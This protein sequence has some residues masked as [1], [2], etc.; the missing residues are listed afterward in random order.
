[1]STTQSK[2]LIRIVL[3]LTVLL[4]IGLSLFS[5]VGFSDGY[6]ASWRSQGLSGA[7]DVA[8][9]APFRGWILAKTYYLLSTTGQAAPP[10]PEAGQHELL[11]D[12]FVLI[13]IRSSGP[14]GNS[15][16]CRMFPDDTQRLDVFC[17]GTLKNPPASLTMTNSVS[18]WFIAG[19]YYCLSLSE[20]GTKGLFFSDLQ[21]ISFGR[22]LENRAEAEDIFSESKYILQL[23]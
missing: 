7:R 3:L 22:F 8:I 18:A 21:C 11:A 14:N 19:G 20:T 13:K 12:G 23:K 2:R 15:G 5:F 9:I 17:G 4:Y 10:K 6:R 16:I 1:M